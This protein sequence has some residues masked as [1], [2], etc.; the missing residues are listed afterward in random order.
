MAYVEIRKN[1]KLVTRRV[2]DDAK[3]QKGCRIR[4][5]SAGRVMLSL[6]ETKQVGKY[7]FQMCEGIIPED[8]YEAVDGLR[9][10]S[11]SFPSMS[12]TEDGA[13]TREADVPPIDHRPP[14]PAIE[15]YK[16]TDRLGAGGMGT[17]WR[18]V[19]SS[20][21]REV[22]MKFLGSH[23]FASK[24]S[25]ARFEREVSL[26]AKLTHP[27]IARVYHSGVHRGVYYYAMELVDG[28]H[29]DSF[30]QQNELSQRDVLELMKDICD[31][32]Y[33]AHKLGV[34][35]RDLKP[36]NIL[37][38][39]DGRPYIVDFGLAKASMQETDDV[40]ISIEGEI[41]G[42]LAYM[43]PEQAAGRTD[44]ISERTDVYSL[45][46]IMHQLLIGRLPHNMS[47]SRYDI[48]K[49]IVEQEVDRP[50]ED[51]EAIGS[52]LEALI[53]TALAQKPEDRYPSAGVFMQDIENHL[54][55]KALYA[56][57]L[58]TAYR[59][60]KQLGKYR[61]PVTFT[62]AC[63]AV[64]LVL[65]AASLYF[66]HL[67]QKKRLAI[68]NQLAGLLEQQQQGIEEAPQKEE[69][70]Y[71][72]DPQNTEDVAIKTPDDGRPTILQYHINTIHSEGGYHIDA[73]ASVDDPQGLGD[74]AN[75]KLIWLQSAI[76]ALP[77]LTQPLF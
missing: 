48:L 16:I 45:G 35:H 1:G 22:A 43:A 44:K 33:H 10:V 55:G 25:R 31:A 46:V 34:I 72:D 53:L 20:T 71:S 40:T 68:E 5:G 11:G 58:S 42:T 63:A 15:G 13:M 4:L 7:E 62:L 70:I 64:L 69:P 12:Q 66:I 39:Q 6:G 30:V 59:I 14:V 60:R 67:E 29:L 26:A 73:K 27:N 38:T 19:Q 51:S 32:V 56:R 65:I 47:G 2:V 49:R 52:D 36:S 54:Q 9:E 18:A 50:S 23:R 8:G 17:V 61:R 41:S 37:V 24:K 77:I 57:S 75:V 3:A 76:R 21:K 74:I 28:V